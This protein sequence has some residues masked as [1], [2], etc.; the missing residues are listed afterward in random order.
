[1]NFGNGILNKISRTNQQQQEAK[2]YGQFI[3][4]KK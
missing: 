2:I 1:M 4:K 3:D